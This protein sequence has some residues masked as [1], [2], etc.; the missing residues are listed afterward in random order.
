MK[1]ILILIC[2]IFLIE[3]STSAQNLISNPKFDDYTTYYDAN[4]NVVYQPNAWH[5]DAKGS[6]HPIYYSSD[7]FLNN[8]ISDNFHPDADLIRQGQKLNYLCALLL[9]KSQR[10][11]TTLKEP[12]KKGKKY[13]LMIDIKAVD[14]SN[15]FSDLLVG[16]SGCSGCN[17][18]LDVLQLSLPDSLCD[19]SLYHNWLTLSKIFTAKGNESVFVISGGSTQDYLKIINANPGKFC[20]SPS[21]NSF[22]LMYFIDNISLTAIDSESDSL[23]S[24]HLDS[25]NIGQSII[26]QNIYFDFDKYVLLKESFPFLDKIAAYLKEKANVRIL[27]SGHTDNV[28]TIEYNYELS[29]KRAKSIVD[30]LMNKGITQDR[31]QSA[32]LG[33]RFPV[34]SNDTDEGRHKNRRIEIKI[35]DK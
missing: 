17:S 9:P 16:F 14:L 10:A 28:G 18:D 20:I 29:N 11:Y 13:Q 1:A 33:S 6:S 7:R 3:I 27:V 2:S 25:L 19:G 22:K 35:I 8:S 15:C 34:D 23:I 5:Y 30:Y 31:L 32:G 24:V 4:N 21:Q 12:L 26:L